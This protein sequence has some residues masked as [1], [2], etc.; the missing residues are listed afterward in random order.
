MVSHL[1]EFGIGGY[2]LTNH[3]CCILRMYSINKYQQIS[4]H[5]STIYMRFGCVWKWSFYHN[6]GN[7]L[8]KG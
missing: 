3:R 4:T 7:Q 5:I 8:G 2:I 6:I 1:L